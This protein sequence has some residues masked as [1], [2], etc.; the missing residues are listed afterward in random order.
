M[1]KSATGPTR[2]SVIAGGLAVMLVAGL[3]LAACS[4]PL[5]SELSTPL[6]PEYLPTAGRA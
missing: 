5:A 6:P 2:I 1:N 3:L 4:N